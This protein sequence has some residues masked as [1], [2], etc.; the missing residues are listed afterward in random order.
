MEDANKDERKS[1]A[2]LPERATCVAPHRHRSR[3]PE[4]DDRH[5]VTVPSPDEEL[6]L[7]RTPPLWVGGALVHDVGERPDARARRRAV[8]TLR[9]GRAAFPSRPVTVR[10]RP[11][12]YAQLLRAGA[13]A[14]SRDRS[15]ARDHAQEENRRSERS[16]AGE[17]DRRRT[18][19]PEAPKPTAPRRLIVLRRF[20]RG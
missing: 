17:P 1:G 20:H 13:V 14:R 15:A 18:L 9:A 6:L 4:L 11:L 2:A 19:R 8:A 12:A 5:G 10:A 7:Q 16:T 3:G